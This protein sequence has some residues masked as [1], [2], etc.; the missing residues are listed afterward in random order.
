M[1]EPVRR[2]PI[3]AGPGRSRPEACRIG[4]DAT[5]L[6]YAGASLSTVAAQ[7]LYEGSG[8][9]SRTVAAWLQRIHDGTGLTGIDVL[10]L[11]EAAMTDDR[12]SLAHRRP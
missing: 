7:N 6:T 12:A 1:A 10:V 2:R 11:D 8:I 3:P 5:G 9:P 4:W